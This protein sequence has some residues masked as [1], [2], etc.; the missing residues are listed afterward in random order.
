M[1]NFINEDCPLELVKEANIQDYC[2]YII[3]VIFIVAFIITITIIIF[4]L[5]LL[6]LNNIIVSLIHFICL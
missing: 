1:I 5:L 6:L 4:I 2:K 3:I